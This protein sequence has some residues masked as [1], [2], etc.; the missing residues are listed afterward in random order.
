MILRAMKVKDLINRRMAE[1]K[2]TQVEAAFSLGWGNS[3]GQYLSNIIRGKCQV[4]VHKIPSLARTLQV[5]AEDIMAALVADYAIT[6]HEVVG[7]VLKE[8]E[9]NP[10]KL[11][12]VPQRKRKK[13]EILKD[14]NLM[15]DQTFV[16]DV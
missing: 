9:K 2:M 11:P 14:L 4:P 15:V 5:P 3:Q 10:P 1:L 8:E 7:A 6:V 12:N 16:D 13:F